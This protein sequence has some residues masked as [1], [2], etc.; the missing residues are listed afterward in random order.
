MMLSSLRNSTLGVSRRWAASTTTSSRFA[1]TLVVSDPLTPAGETPPATQS[2]VTAASKFGQPVDLLVVSSTVPTKIPQGVQ[3]LY[4]VPIG[5]RLAESVASS[6]Q[7]VVR[8]KGCNIVVGIASK[9]GST[10]IPRAAALLDVSP[11]TDVLEI[12]DA[13]TYMYIIYILY[14]MRRRPWIS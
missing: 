12:Q 13:G 5:D 10:I 6:I 3:K 14:Y 7:A 11:I 8:D 9:F 1:S 2:A 4:H